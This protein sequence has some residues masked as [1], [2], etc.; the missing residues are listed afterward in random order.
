MFRDLKTFLKDA[1]IL[2][3]YM[4]WGYKRLKI[5]VL[6]EISLPPENSVVFI[7]KTRLFQYI[8]NFTIK[9]GKF[10]DKKL[11]YFFFIF[12]LKP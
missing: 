1:A 12:L 2:N 10:S 4:Y 9:K 11:W 5:L 6:N 8:E 7:T 3:S